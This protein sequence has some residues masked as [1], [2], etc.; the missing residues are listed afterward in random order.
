MV[1]HTLLH[2][3]YDQV[4]SQTTSLQITPVNNY[5][6]LHGQT[7]CFQMAATQEE[8]KVMEALTGHVTASVSRSLKQHQ[9]QQLLRLS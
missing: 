5:C 7:F 2:M 3:N 4:L 1:S 6:S 9:E 8:G